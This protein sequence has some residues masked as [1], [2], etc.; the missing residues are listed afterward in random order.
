M[1]RLRLRWLKD[2]V[3]D[4]RELKVKKW[5]GTDNKASAIKVAVFVQDRRAREYVSNFN[6]IPPSDHT[7][8]KKLVLTKICERNV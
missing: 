5:R 3:C 4:L 2:V 8:Q 6:T 1:G 7:E